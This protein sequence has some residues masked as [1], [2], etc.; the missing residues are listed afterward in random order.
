M[1]ETKINELMDSGRPG[2]S[3]KNFLDSLLI[4]RIIDCLQ[5]LTNE[6]R[7]I[8]LLEIGTGS[9]LLAHQLL[10]RDLNIR[11]VG[12]EPTNTLRVATT[13]VLKP[14][15]D[16][17]TMLDSSLPDLANISDASFDACIMFHLLEHATDQIQAH[18]WLLSILKKVKPGGRVIIVCPNHFDYKS[19]FYDGDWSH[20]Y[21]TT[22]RRIEL[23]GVDV[24]FNPLETT[25]LRGNCDNLIVKGLLGLISKAIPTGFINLLGQ[26]IFGIRYLGM[27]LQAALFWRN[28]WVVLERPEKR[29]D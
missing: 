11:Y 26:K 2:K 5:P 29:M 23:L 20:G 24:G 13:E 22:S 17:V 4:E 15:G 18:N 3:F 16:R 9:G 1:Y 19:Y 14:F 27:G 25:D 7:N 8:Q 6:D 12:V 10:S 21:P 28:C